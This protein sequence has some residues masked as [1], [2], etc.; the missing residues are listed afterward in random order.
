MIDLGVGAKV[1]GEIGGLGGVA[2]VE[3]GNVV[4]GGFVEKA[5]SPASALALAL[6]LA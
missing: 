5:A 3:C 4:G 6:T 1:V 2:A